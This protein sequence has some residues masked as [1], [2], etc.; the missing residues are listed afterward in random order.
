MSKGVFLVEDHDE[1]LKIWRQKG[2][3]NLDLVHID[4]HVDFGFYQAKPIA[5]II[6]EAKNLRE[7]KRDLECSLAY[8]HYEND[9]D[10]QA[11]IGNYIYPAMREGIVKD[12]YWVIPGG[13]KEFRESLGLIKNI[14]RNLTRQRHYS[15]DAKEGI[16]SAGI[17][18]RKFIVCALAKLPILRQ[19]A[20]LDI[21]TDFLVI[22]SIVNAQNTANIGKRKPWILPKDLAD[23]LKKKIKQ[24]RIITI[25]YSVNGGYT[26]MEYKHLGDEIACNFSPVEFKNRLKA[27]LAAADNFNLFRFTGRKEYYEKAII[28]NPAYR[29]SDNNYGPLYLSLGKLSLAEKEF[30][31]AL[32]VDLENSACLWGLG[33]ISLKRNNFKKAKTYFSLALK[34]CNQR[35]FN[36]I[37]KQCLLSLAT[38]EFEIGNIH[39]AKKLLLRYKSFERLNAQSHYLLG[40][41]YEKERRFLKAVIFYKNS[42]ILGFDMLET[43]LRLL[44]IAFLL[45]KEHAIID[46]VAE[47]YNSFKAVF[48]KERKLENNGATKK[49]DRIGKKMRVIEKMLSKGGKTNA[50]K[51]R[52]T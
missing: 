29:A 1:A 6:T 41:I 25:A 4:A 27:A 48:L 2:F 44:K 15:I 10:R 8:K 16:I 31:K 45:N 35:L 17:L 40:R 21:D 7:L 33:Q 11:N 32:R 12:F 19:E 22:D 26:P 28:Y 30:S 37:E 46:L 13:L 51:N 23:K 38:A 36:K 49:W 52:S 24:P 43:I 50:R 34:G 20:L 47:R 5:D 9:F 18:G 39:K 42:L 14:I 3:K